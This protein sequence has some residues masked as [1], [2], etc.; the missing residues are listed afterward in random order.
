MALQNL[1]QEADELNMAKQSHLEEG[2]LRVW[3]ARFP[4]LPEPIRQHKFAKAEGRRWMLDFAFVDHRLG[5]EIDGGEF[6]N[7]GHNRGLQ[8]QKDLE[9]DRAAV[10]LGWR[11]LRYVGLDL[12]QRP[13]QMV[14]EIAA[15]LEVLP[16]AG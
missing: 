14:E 6:I 16:V 2:F 11:V 12:R 5:I 4:N 3:K 7:G 15:L 13:V 9:K 1:H 10:R 8:R